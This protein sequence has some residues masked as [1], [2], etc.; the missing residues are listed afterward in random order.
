MVLGFLSSALNMGSTS[1]IKAQLSKATDSEVIDV[2]KDLFKGILEA[3]NDEQSRR[4]IM[5]HIFECFTQ[6]TKAKAWRRVHAALILT[7]ELVLN[8]SPSLSFE[9]NSGYHF[10][11]LQ[12]LSFLEH[13]ELVTNRRA[14]ATVRS[15]AQSVR[16]LVAPKLALQEISE[17]ISQICPE[18]IKDKDASEDTAST[19]SIGESLVTSETQESDSTPIDEQESV[20]DFLMYA[21]QGEWVTRKGSNLK[22]D[23]SVA[24][25]SCGSAGSLFVD[26]EFLYLHIPNDTNEY[27]AYLRMEDG[28]L[29]WS[30]GDFWRRP[31]NGP[32]HPQQ[33][34]WHG[35]L[36]PPK[37]S[38]RL[39][40]KK[41]VTP[42]IHGIVSVGHSC[43]T[44]SESSADET[45]LPA[46]I[47]GQR[48]TKTRR[49]R[50]HKSSSTSKTSSESDRQADASQDALDLLS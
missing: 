40:G 38:L 12:Q 15:K 49:E 3:S 17:V 9:I 28:V 41:P 8:G 13:F 24:T 47:R 31:S 19:C 42:I 23:G 7:E 44:E 14:Q 45:P 1:A 33:E 30:D 11:L 20:T 26:G 21:V 46:R 48:K 39:S 4:T 5:M 43:D 10:D 25:F 2:P 32:I 29:C 6:S 37:N 34:E 18:P 50:T 35:V 16:R 22:I 27:H 36:L